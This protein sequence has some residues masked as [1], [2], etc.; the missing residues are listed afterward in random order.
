MVRDLTGARSNSTVTI[1]DKNGTVL[2]T[3]EEQNAL[4]TEHFKEVLN[5]IEPLITFAFD[6]LSIPK[7]LPVNMA[8]ITEEETDRAIKA[9]EN[10]KAAGLDEISAELLK[11][12]TW[13]P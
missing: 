12:Q 13:R 2:L 10:N 4:W 7:D 3:H 1:K 8:D 5:Q 6:T 9:V 11:H